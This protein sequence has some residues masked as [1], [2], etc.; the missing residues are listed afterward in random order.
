MKKELPFPKMGVSVTVKSRPLN[1]T[2]Q[3]EKKPEEKTKRNHG[4]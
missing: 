2:E 4:H 1:K 3:K